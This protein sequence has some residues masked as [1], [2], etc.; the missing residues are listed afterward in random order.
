MTL[1]KDSVSL[2]LSGDIEA[3]L[4]GFVDF[5]IR[6]IAIGGFCRWA[7]SGYNVDEHNQEM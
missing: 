7:M 6:S 1:Q 2:S 5:A 4:D 3:D